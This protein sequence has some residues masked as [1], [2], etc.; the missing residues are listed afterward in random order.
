LYELILVS[1]DLQTWATMGN[2]VV[3]FDNFKIDYIEST[4]NYL[5]VKMR[6]DITQ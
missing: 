5:K 2:F 4:K 1:N 6:T 3:M